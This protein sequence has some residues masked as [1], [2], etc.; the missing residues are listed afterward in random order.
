MQFHK[1]RNT[2]RQIYAKWLL[3]IEICELVKRAVSFIKK[4]LVK[5]RR[6]CRH[7]PVRLIA[8]ITLL[9]I[10]RNL[11]VHWSVSFWSFATFSVA[12]GI[13]FHKDRLRIEIQYLDLFNSK[14]GIL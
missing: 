2:Q 14:G 10:L 5:D 3:E 6:S 7:V 13:F 12:I 1:N 4:E 8:V 9:I 11:Q